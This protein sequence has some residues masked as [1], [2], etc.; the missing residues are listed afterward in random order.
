MKCGILP[1]GMWLLFQGSFAK[2]LP[3]LTRESAKPIMQKAN[4]TY[5]GI[6]KDIPDFDRNDRF[7]VNILSAAMLAGVYLNLREKPPLDAVTAYYH[8]AMTEASVMRRF[9][10]RE[11]PYTPKAQAKLKR[12][13]EDSRHRDNPYSWKFRYE[14]GPD[15]SSYS[16]YFDT[17][18]ILY[19]FQKLGIPEITPAMCSYD[20]DMAA[21]GGS[22]FT[23][24]HT[25]AEGGPCCDCHYRKR[26]ADA[27][28]APSHTK[29]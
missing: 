17:C 4:K 21:M 26:A 1:R 24:R 2:H 9:I 10:K 19:L 14:A 6:L 20:Y 18:G 8:S 15:G 29:G 5:R 25:L 28:A 23:R 13:A 16:A 22:V 27:P 7:L 11:D 3:L 12:Q